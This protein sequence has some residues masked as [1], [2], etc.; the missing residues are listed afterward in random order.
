MNERGV[1]IL[2]EYLILMGIL[3]VFIVVMSLSLDAQLKSSQISKV[4]ENQFSDVASQLSAQLV[5]MASLYPKDGYIKAKIYMP[6]SIGGVAYRLNFSEYE[7]TR[8]IY[9]ESDDYRLTKTLSLGA[10]ASLK[11]ENMSGIVY[12]LQREGKVELR[13]ETID[14]PTA[15]LKIRPNSVISGNNVTIDVS[16]S[17][18][19]VFWTWKVLDWNENVIAEGDKNERVKEVTIYWSAEIPTKCKDYSIGNN[20]ESAVCEFTLILTDERGYSAEDSEEILIANRPRVEP[21]LYLKK[22]V[23]PE[24]V[25][26]GQAFDLHLKL[27]GRGLVLNETRKN[28]SVVTVIDKSDRMHAANISEAHSERTLYESFTRVVQPSVATFVFNVNSTFKSH[29]FYLYLNVSSNPYLRA[30]AFTIYVTK[31]NGLTEEV[32]G[33]TSYEDKNI[34]NSEVGDWTL[35]ILVA[36]K[37]STTLT[38]EIYSG[39]NCPDGKS[40]GLRNTTTIAYTPNVAFY[41]FSFPVGYTKNN[42]YEFAYVYVKE[43]YTNSFYLWL[44]DEFCNYYSEVNGIV[45]FS[46]NINAEQSYTVYI[47]P[48]LKNATFIEGEL[49]MEKLDAAKIG[50]IRFVNE[51]L[52]ENDNK[53]VVSFSTSASID[54]K[55]T[56]DNSLVIS[57]IKDITAS[58]WTNYLLAL[59]K[60]LEVLEENKEIVNGTKPLI[61]FLSDGKP[62]CKRVSNCNDD[63]NCYQIEGEYF[64]CGDKSCQQDDCGSQVIPKA[65]EIKN[66]TIGD[67]YID[68][69]TIGFGDKSYYNETLLKLMSGR[70][71]PNNPNEI[72]ECY[73]SARN[74]QELIDAFTR[75]GKLYERAATNVT[76]NDT[77]PVS[78]ELYLYPEVKPELRIDGKANCK[79]EL[80]FVEGTRILMSCT[81]IYIDD[82]VEIV[83]RLTPK[84]TGT[85]KINENGVVVY[86]DVNYVKREVRLPEMWIEVKNPSGAEVKIS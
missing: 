79:L 11:F 31:P 74:L 51:S 27:V 37:N 76:L 46:Q 4:A 26:L 70:R 45:C 3:S 52:N 29:E 57:K 17:Y 41:N 38:L 10:F 16:D 55:L 39:K 67:E 20:S 49:W 25:T 34:D 69:C 54:Q 86:Y 68:I 72:L 59:N 6:A 19:P 65:N 35:E 23:V 40:C 21:D 44:G 36:D 58:G 60:S 30:S 85:L 8:S 42:V 15:V 5:D 78:I 28:L 71:N 18:S 66:T 33:K 53:S 13:R 50:A 73:Y 22:F 47:V 48:R 81:E 61:V 63:T 56:S 7:G 75:I 83:I 1:S 2:I 77:I 9:I 24:T 80:S 14:Y 43:T 64:I 62:T 32:Y 82:V 84:E 12:S